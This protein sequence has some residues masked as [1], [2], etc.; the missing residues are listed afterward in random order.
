MTARQ[1]S[2]RD[3]QPR[4]SSDHVCSDE[5]PGVRN[6]EKPEDV[7][8]LQPDQLQRMKDPASPAAKANRM[9]GR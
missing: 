5:A 7:D 1:S 6:S 4:R 3:R 9:T 8:E 2:R